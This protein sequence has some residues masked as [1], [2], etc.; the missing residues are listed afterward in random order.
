MQAKAEGDGVKPE[1]KAPKKK[2]SKKSKKAED[3][4]AG[5][6]E[7]EDDQPLYKKLEEKSKDPKSWLKTNTE[8]LDVVWCIMPPALFLYLS[9]FCS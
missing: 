2:Q 4:D 8:P 6:S 5:P 1:K 7:S 9:V 3:E